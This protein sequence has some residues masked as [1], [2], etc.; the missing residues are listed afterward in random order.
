MRLS[1][2]PHVTIARWKTTLGDFRLK[3]LHCKSVGRQRDVFIS[4]YMSGIKFAVGLV[5]AIESISVGFSRTLGILR[6]IYT[7]IVSRCFSILL[8]QFVRAIG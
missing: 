2:A 6:V 1:E 7:E 4:R 8:L 3:S 5:H